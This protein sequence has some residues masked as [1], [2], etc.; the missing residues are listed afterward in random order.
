M[1]SVA[2]RTIKQMAQVR[3]KGYT[4]KRGGKL[5]TVRPHVRTSALGLARRAA[6]G[7]LSLRHVAS[8]NRSGPRIGQRFYRVQLVPR[9]EIG[10]PHMMSAEEARAKVAYRGAVSDAVARLEFAERHFQ[11]HGARVEAHLKKIGRA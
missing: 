8:R 3:V 1:L 4:Y 6:R 5:V 7:S 9:S 2:V 10:H 11:R